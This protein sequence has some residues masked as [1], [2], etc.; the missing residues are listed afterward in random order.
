MT[1]QIKKLLIKNRWT[2]C[3]KAY[4]S[5][6]NPDPRDGRFYTITLGTYKK[7]GGYIQSNVYDKFMNI[8]K[9]LVDIRHEVQ[10]IDNDI[11]NGARFTV[12]VD[13]FENFMTQ[14]KN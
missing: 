4:G 7:N 3:T 8:S 5:K 12:H 9:E 14:I 10:K 1:D 2:I 11:H 13:D 6:Q